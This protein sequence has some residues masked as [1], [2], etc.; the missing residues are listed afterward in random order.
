MKEIK[1]NSENSLRELLLIVCVRL[2]LGSARSGHEDNSRCGSTY[3]EA[4]GFG[5]YFL[6]QG[7]KEF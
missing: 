3:L 1:K 4:L 5:N 7:K 6:L 2:T